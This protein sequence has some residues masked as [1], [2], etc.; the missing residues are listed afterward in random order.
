[1]NKINSK[2][3]ILTNVDLKFKAC[4]LKLSWKWGAKDPEKEENHL[5]FINLG[6]NKFTLK[7]T[8]KKRNVDIWIL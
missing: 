1:M 8:P 5:V 2:S 7:N 3:L 6:V 4:V